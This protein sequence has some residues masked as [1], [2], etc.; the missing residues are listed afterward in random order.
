MRNRKDGEKTRSRILKAASEV[1]SEKGFHEA[2]HAQICRRANANTAAIN[3]HFGS[4]EELYREVWQ[5][6]I[7]TMNCLYPVGGAAVAGES[8]EERLLHFIKTLL[9]K[10]TARGEFGD[11]HRL[12][13]QEIHH[14]TGIIDDLL[15]QSRAPYQ[16]Y[17]LLIIRELLGP[18]AGENTIKYCEKSIIGQVRAFRFGLQNPPFSKTPHPNGKKIDQLAEHIARFS[19]A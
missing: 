17:L 14:P 6:T 3:Y 18:G 11:S 12:H 2:T 1:F 7:A 5:H 9:S 15:R 13:L 16:A 10:M 8:P 19:L 4:K